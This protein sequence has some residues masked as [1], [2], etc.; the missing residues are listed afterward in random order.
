MGSSA[1]IKSLLNTPTHKK[2]I[3]DSALQFAGTPHFVLSSSATKFVRA[4]ASGHFIHPESRFPILVFRCGSNTAAH[5]LPT[6]LWKSRVRRRSTAK[7]CLIK[8]G[9]HISSFSSFA[10]QAC[11][12][13]GF[14]SRQWY[15]QSK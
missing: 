3:G 12:S 8:F 14:K 9:W 5:E 15:V 7:F 6:L 2:H 4:F 11:S 13:H 1:Q 10:F